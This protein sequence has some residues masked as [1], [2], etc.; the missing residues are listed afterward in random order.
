MVPN[1]GVWHRRGSVAAPSPPVARLTD[2]GVFHGEPERRRGAAD[3]RRMTFD[4]N[5]LLAVLY[6]NHDR[7]LVRIEQ[8]ANVQL[9]ARGNQLAISGTPDDAAVAQKAISGLLQKRRDSFGAELKQSSTQAQ[10]R[11]SALQQRLADI[12]LEA[13][14]AEAKIVLQQQRV[15]LSEQNL[16]RF[17]DLQATNFISAAQL[18]DR[19]AELIDQQQRLA[20]LQSV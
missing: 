16:K 8:L 7:N 11:L 19:Q 3:V 2:A 15:T 4:N 20:D 13:Q 6:G 17:K 5:T 14:R 12:R 9:S 1:G 18:Q 10:Q